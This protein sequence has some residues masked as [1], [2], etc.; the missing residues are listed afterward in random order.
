[1]RGEP[2]YRSSGQPAA[3]L[4]SST[5]AERDR[6]SSTPAEPVVVELGDR[7]VEA[8]ADALAGRLR[9]TAPPTPGTTLVTAAAVSVMLGCTVAWVRQHQADLGV[10]KV[11]DGPRPR[12]LFDASIVAERVV[13]CSASRKSER[14]ESP[15]RTGPTPRGRRSPL[16]T[17]VEMLPIRVPKPPKSPL[18]EESG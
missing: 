18:V 11:G 8:L 2:K 12:L 6:V 7:S 16:G 9:G 14:P 15:V 3:V 10:I 4:G 13:S 5:R 17:D 1:M